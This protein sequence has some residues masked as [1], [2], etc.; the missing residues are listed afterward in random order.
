MGLSTAGTSRLTFLGMRYEVLSTIKSGAMG[1][2]Y[3]AWDAR[4]N[5]IVALKRMNSSLKDP[6]EIRYAEERFREEASLLSKLHHGGLPKVIDFFTEVD[7]EE[8]RPVHFLV[9][10]FIDGPDLET[11]ITTRKGRPFDVDEVLSYFTQILRILQYLHS[12]TPPVIYRD[13]NPRNIMIQEEKIFLVDF[14]IARVFNPQQQGTAIGTPGYTA[15]EQYKGFAEPRSD[16]Y[17][18]GAVMHYLLTGV[19]PEGHSHTLFSFTP[20]RKVNPDVPVYLERLIMSMVDLIP[21]RR[22]SSAGEVE[23]MLNNQGKKPVLS[24]AGTPAQYSDI[25]QA[26]KS[27][28][29]DTIRGFIKAGADVNVKND[30]GLSPLHIAALCGQKEATRILISEGADINIQNANGHTPLKYAREK[31]HF[32]VAGLLCAHGVSEQADSSGS[33]SLASR[34]AISMQPGKISKRAFGVALAAVFVLILLFG[35]LYLHSRQRDFQYLMAEAQSASQS[36]NYDAAAEYASGAHSIYPNDPMAKK[37]LIHYSLYGAQQCLSQKNFSGCRESLTMLFAADPGN[38][39][40]KKLEEL[41]NRKMKI[42][43]CLSRGDHFFGSRN[44]A[45][46]CI[47]YAEALKFEPDN[48]FLKQKIAGMS[49]GDEFLVLLDASIKALQQKEFTFARETVEKALCIFPYDEEAKHLRND[50]NI[51][52]ASDLLEKK[53]NEKAYDAAWTALREA[54]DSS[55]A[56]DLFFRAKSSWLQACLAEGKRLFK[57]NELDNARRHFKKALDIDPGNNEAQKS[58]S[59]IDDRMSKTVNSWKRGNAFFKSGQYEQAIKCY[60]TAL[61]V[62]SKNPEIKEALSKAYLK[63]EQELRAKR[64]HRGSRDTEP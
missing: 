59:S 7:P 54:P 47:A 51:A 16:I 29:A 5:N 8:H 39:E 49:K 20:V 41:I 26:V 40:G 6:E 52:V 18:L 30:E 27:G 64:L 25:F 4:L 62:D 55:D 50:I 46:A 1:C 42:E 10:T 56:N 60:E 58:I 3:K 32:E 19:N 45:K 48:Q 13:L 44:F 43:E 22:P 34:S 28:D 61:S 14:G 23:R 33:K 15:P 2:V 63:R 31:G 57:L 38:T 11:M 24:S 35:G 9:M 37:M 21:E 53:E 12:E 36:F 17:S